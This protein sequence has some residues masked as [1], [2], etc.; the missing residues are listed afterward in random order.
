MNHT[1]ILIALVDAMYPWPSCYIQSIVDSQTASSSWQVL[2]LWTQWVN[3]I[4]WLY[5]VIQTTPGNQFSFK[6][7][8][9]YNCSMALFMTFPWTN[10]WMNE[11]KGLHT[12]CVFL[13]HQTWFLG[14]FCARYANFSK[15]TCLHSIFFYVN[16]NFNGSWGLLNPDHRIHQIW[17]HGRILWFSFPLGIHTSTH[18]IKFC[19]QISDYWYIEMSIFFLI[20]EYYTE[21]KTWFLFWLLVLKG[22]I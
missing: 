4:G 19:L 1:S 6:K 16:Y 17:G 10:V 8:I 20:W 7:C 13:F 11:L 15:H 21:I 12:S 5:V 18:I 3:C 9:K 22:T 14:V 2:T